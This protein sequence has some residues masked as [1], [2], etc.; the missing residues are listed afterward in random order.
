V[1]AFDRL[2]FL[3]F[4]QL[5]EALLELEGGIPAGAWVGEAD[6]CRSVLSGA[7]LEPPLADSVLAAPVLLQCAWVRSGDRRELLEAVR[8]LVALRPE[9]FSVAA[10]FDC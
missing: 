9:D 8:A 5:C 7:P 1:Y 10:S 2:G 6:R 3:Q 4:E